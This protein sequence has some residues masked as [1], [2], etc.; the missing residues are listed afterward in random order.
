LTWTVSAHAPENTQN[1]SVGLHLVDDRPVPNALNSFSSVQSVALAWLVH[2]EHRV[3]QAQRDSH[4]LSCYRRDMSLLGALGDLPVCSV[5]PPDVIEWHE[6]LCETV[7]SA[8][9]YAA[10]S[11]VRVLFG[12]ARRRGLIPSNTAARLDIT[13]RAK[14]ARPLTPEE[15]VAWRVALDQVEAKRLA[16]AASRDHEPARL[17]GML[18]SIRALRLLE[19][20]G[21]RL[22]EIC[23]IPVSAVRLK[24]RCLLLERTKTG[25]SAVPLAPQ[26]LALVAQQVEHVRGCSPWLFP[27]PVSAL[28]HIGD[29]AVWETFHISCGLADIRGAHPHDLRHGWIWTALSE[30]VSMAD[31][32]AGAGHRTEQ[33][34]K[35]VYAN[36][37]L[38][39]PGMFR[40]AQVVQDARTN[41]ANGFTPGE[42]GGL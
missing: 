32:S 15:V 14:P 38:L 22:F 20:T 3:R 31:T 13:H 24:S 25:P 16:W 41:A 2:L 17:L 28:R 19:L 33:A 36:G 8:R 21:R 30:G 27:S 12:F 39:F 42:R 37:M 9:A 10:Y 11:S 4:T 1:S 40:A 29:N 35:K 26:A 7:T 23:S 18:S 5:T 34:T 6:R